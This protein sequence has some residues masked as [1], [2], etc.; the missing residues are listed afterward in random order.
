MTVGITDI[1][2]FPLRDKVMNSGV[3]LVNC[4]ENQV[5]TVYLDNRA[6]EADIVLISE[7]SGIS[8]QCHETNVCRRNETETDSTALFDTIRVSWGI[9]NTPTIVIKVQ[10]ICLE[11]S[12]TNGYT[13]PPNTE[14]QGQIR[15]GKK[16]CK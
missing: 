2:Q 3:A 11:E 1:T 6:P 16:C 9:Q 13:S 10:Y 14:F 4:A 7:P 5:T 15:K 12:T 8:V